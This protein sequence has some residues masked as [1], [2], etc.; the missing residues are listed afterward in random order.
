MGLNTV[1]KKWLRDPTFNYERINNQHGELS[2]DEIELLRERPSHLERLVH[3]VVSVVGR[4]SHQETL[5]TVW[6]PGESLRGADF[7]RRRLPN[8]NFAEADLRNAIFT[9]TV[10]VEAV[11]A[12]ADL[13]EA[14]LA[15]AILTGADLRGTNLS[16]ANLIGTD[17]GGADLT[18]A[19]LSGA[20][21][22]G[23]D[24]NDANLDCCVFTGAYA[25]GAL[26]SHA[27]NLT[28]E[29]FRSTIHDE[30]GAYRLSMLPDPPSSKGS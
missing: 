14:N 29:Q 24:F 26:F 22:W 7:S 30:T 19:D 27:R 21:I 8:A 9:G 4:H 18:G 5:Q 6:H 10:L 1:D 13:R 15:E 16:G 17:F 20:Y 2:D 25:G 3:R 12:G 28:L 23:A 11:F